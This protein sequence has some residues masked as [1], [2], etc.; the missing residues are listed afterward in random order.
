MHNQHTWADP[1]HYHSKKI[2]KQN[3]KLTFLK[4]LLR[5]E[6]EWQLGTCEQRGETWFGLEIEA[7]SAKL[8]AVTFAH[9]SPSYFFYGLQ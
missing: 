3:S 2:L 9:C 6:Q 4:T 7:R 8:S 5:F 1:P